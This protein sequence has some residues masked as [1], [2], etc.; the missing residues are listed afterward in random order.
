MR[1]ALAMILLGLFAVASAFSCDSSYPNGVPKG[2]LTV[3]VQSVESDYKTDGSNDAILTLMRVAV[4]ISLTYTATNG[5]TYVEVDNAKDANLIVRVY[6]HHKEGSDKYSMDLVFYGLGKT[7]DGHT[8]FTAFGDPEPNMGAALDQVIA[9]TQDFL[10]N[11]WTC[12]K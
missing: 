10:Q 2:K 4:P 8:L 12:D 5:N 1:K 11:G 6:G 3:Y 9:S 7:A